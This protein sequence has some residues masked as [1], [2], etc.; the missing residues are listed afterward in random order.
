M[1]CLHTYKEGKKARQT[2]KGVIRRAQS[3]QI[4]LQVSLHKGPVL[5]HVSQH[6]LCHARHRA[7]VA[8]VLHGAL[9][10]GVHSPEAAHTQTR[11]TPVFAEAK[12]DMYIAVHILHGQTM[13]LGLGGQY[14]Q[15]RE[16]AVW[17][18]NGVGINFVTAQTKNAGASWPDLLPNEVVESL[19]SRTEWHS[20]QLH[21]QQQQQQQAFTF[22]KHCSFWFA[23]DLNRVSLMAITALG[24][25]A[26]THPLDRGEDV[27]T[28]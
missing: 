2:C 24:A 9:H 6:V 18:E 25:K 4:L 3:P 8:Q 20:Y 17:L 15:T 14:C 10:R 23:C 1:S 21:R 11:C 26:T 12:H 7:E 27:A 5:Q 22:C 13:L 28:T 16:L 19:H